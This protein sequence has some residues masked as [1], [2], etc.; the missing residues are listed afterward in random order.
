MTHTDLQSSRNRLR[1]L[2]APSESLL[3][4]GWRRIALDLL[5]LMGKMM[6]VQS[7]PL[8][9]RF[10]LKEMVSRDMKALENFEVTDSKTG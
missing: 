1:Q 5:K 8:P 10:P 9:C 6:E 4:A 7:G 3:G 2:P